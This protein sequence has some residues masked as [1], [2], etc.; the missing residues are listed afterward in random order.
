MTP[1]TARLPTLSATTWDTLVKKV[2]AGS[3]SSW[4][5]VGEMGADTQVF[6]SSQGLSKSGVTRFQRRCRFPCSVCLAG[7]L[8]PACQSYQQ[9]MWSWH[10]KV[11]RTPLTSHPLTYLF[12]LVSDPRSL[13]VSQT[14]LELV[15]ASGSAS[16]MLGSQVYPTISHLHLYP[17]FA[18]LL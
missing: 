17:L 7:V 11:H 16:Q 3:H 4:F 6:L 9:W 14:D 12:H 18:V 5:P 13:C 2:K 10:Y 15:G 8:S 1:L